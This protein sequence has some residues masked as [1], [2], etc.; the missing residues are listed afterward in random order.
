MKEAYPSGC[1][2]ASLIW[3]VVFVLFLSLCQDCSSYNEDSKRLFVDNHVFSLYCAKA[4]CITMRMPL[5]NV[6]SCRAAF[7]K[8]TWSNAWLGLLFTGDAQH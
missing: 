2:Y 1:G 3:H 8:C 6:T 5:H 4:T 7:M